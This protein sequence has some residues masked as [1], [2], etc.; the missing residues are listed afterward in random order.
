MPKNDLKFE[1]KNII[2]QGYTKIDE[3][4]VKECDARFEERLSEAVYA[5]M[6]G[7]S[8]RVIGLTGPT[9]S[10]KTTAAKKLI[11][12]LGDEEKRVQFI[13]LDD[14]YKTV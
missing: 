11:E 9:C 3:N 8:S 1:N 4:F 7:N 12:Y 2:K 13:S 14:F 10:G 6:E 5:F